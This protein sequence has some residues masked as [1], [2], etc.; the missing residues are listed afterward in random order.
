MKEG[1]TRWSELIGLSTEGCSVPHHCP[2]LNKYLHLFK[3]LGRHYTHSLPSSVL[4]GPLSSDTVPTILHQASWQD[5]GI[6][7]ATTDGQWGDEG[8]SWGHLCGG[9]KNWREV[10]L[11]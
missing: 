9:R 8:S 2:N 7:T 4:G 11:R 3:D 6:S 10:R 5:M 1:T